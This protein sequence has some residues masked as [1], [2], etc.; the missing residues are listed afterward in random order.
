VGGIG[1][2]DGGRDVV[3][4]AVRENILLKRGQRQDHDG[5]AP[6]PGIGRE[7]VQEALT[8]PGRHDDGNR[9]VAAYDITQSLPLHAAEGDLRTVHAAEDSVYVDSGKRYAPL[10]LNPRYLVLYALLLRPGR[11]VVVSETDEAMPSLAGRKVPLPRR[12]TSAAD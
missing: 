12:S 1:V 7:L 2:P 9:S 4:V 3:V 6:L 11:C 5:Q 8:P 10:I